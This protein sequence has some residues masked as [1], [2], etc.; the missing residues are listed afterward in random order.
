MSA[1]KTTR[2][3]MKILSVLLV[4]CLL[5]PLVPF[6]QPVVVEAAAA[7][8]V[9]ITVHQANI[10]N[11]TVKAE[12]MFINF[13]NKVD[14]FS[15]TNRNVDTTGMPVGTLYM[16]EGESIELTIDI[17]KNE[18]L[19]QLAASGEA[20]VELGWS[21]LLWSEEG[22][23]KYNYQGTYALMQV[24]SG[25]KETGRL[26][27]EA[28]HGGVGTRSL[29]VPIAEDTVIFIRVAGIRDHIGQKPVGVSGMYVRFKDETP[30]VLSSYSLTGDG[31]QRWN[32]TAERQEL[33]VKENEKID[34][35]YRFSEPV[36][37][38]GVLPTAN[39]PVTVAFLKHPLFVNTDQTGLPG[40]GVQQYLV[41]Q[42]YAA[43]QTSLGKYYSDITY[44]YTG[45]R[46]HQNGNPLQPAI[47]A[48]TEANLAPTLSDKFKAAEFI[49][50]AGNAA[51]VDFAQITAD[52]NSD[53]Y[54]RN[55]GI[56]NPFDFEN[57]GGFGIIVDAVRPKYS[58]TSN[59]IQPE[60]LTGVTVNNN[61]TIDFTVQFSE[62]V[63]PWR[64]HTSEWAAEDTYLEFN[65][66]MKAYYV[67]GSGTDKWK[68]RITLTDDVEL[69]TALLK[70]IALA[71]DNKDSDTLVLQ[72]YAGNMLFQ[73]A[74]YKGIHNDG[75]DSLMDSTIDWANLMIDNTKPDINFHFETGG[76]SADTY[77]KN[78]KVT[79]AADDP[80]LVVPPLEP[81]K[82]GVVLPEALPSRG[83]YRPTNMTGAGAPSVGLVYYIWSQSPDNP[84]ADKDGD[85]YAA[86]KRYSL[87]GK[88]PRED[89][90][91]NEY[92]DLNLAVVNNKTNMIA[93]PPE[94]LLPENSG[95]WYMHAWTADMTWDS[96]REL[97]QYEKMKTF[98]STREG[99]EQYQIWMDEHNGS[100][101]D[102]KTYA[103]AKALASVGN[104]VEWDL[105]DFKQADSNWNYGM[106]PFL[107]DN[108]QPDV[109]FTNIEGNAT[110]EAIVAVHLADPHSGLQSAS[111][112]FVRTGEQPS[113]AEWKSM[114]V[115]SG[116]NANI[117]TLN[118][119]Y[120]DGEYVLFVQASDAAGNQVTTSLEQTIVIDSTST[121]RVAF[122]P[123]ENTSYVKTHDVEYYLSGL[124]PASVSYA[125]SSSIVRPSDASAYTTVTASVYREAGDPDA[126]TAPP[127]GGEY[128][129]IIPINPNLNGMQYVHVVVD[130]GD[131]SRIYTYAKAYYFDNEPP[132]VGFSRTSVLYPQ[133]SHE[134]TVTVAE[135]AGRALVPIRLYQWVKEDEP[136]PDKASAGWS[137]LA[138]NGL[139]TIDAEEL[140]Q[141]GETANYRLYVY[142][143][144]AAGNG[145][146][147]STG[148]FAISR[149]DT[150][151]PPS[152]GESSL[153]HLYGDATDG[154]TG[155]I[156]LDLET[157]DKRGYEYSIS[158]DGG[159]SWS[160]WQ[161]YTNFVSTALPTN[162]V[163][164]LNIQV[165]FRKSG[166][167]A[168]EPQPLQIGELSVTEPVYAIARLSTTRPIQSATGVDIQITPPLGVKV[169]AAE[170]NPPTGLEQRGNSFK[171]RENGYYAF[172]LTDL[173]DPDR[174]DKLYVVVNNIDDTPPWG[175]IYYMSTAPTNGNAVVKLETMEPVTVLQLEIL[176]SDTL[177]SLSVLDNYGRNT[178]TFTQNGSVRFKFADEAGNIAAVIATV[179][180]IDKQSPNVRIAK[181]YQ[182]GL[183]T[184]ESFGT[185]RDGVGNVL[186]SSGVVLTVEK[187]HPQDK[188]FSVIG[189]ASSVVVQRNGTYS[190]TVSDSYGNTTQIAETVSNIVESGP[191]PAEVTYEFVDANGNVLPE[192]QVKTI[193]GKRYAKGKMRI[194]IAG[195]TQP[196]NIVFQGGTPILDE[197]GHYTNQISDA[198]GN[199]SLTRTVEDNGSMIIAL[200]DLVGNTNKLAL[201]VEGLDN[202]PPE[203]AVKHRVAGIVQ[204]KAGFDA[205]IDL[206]GYVASDNVSDA[207]NIAVT[208]S[209]LDLSKPGRQ[210]VTY[211]AVDEVGNSAQAKQDVYVVSGEGILIFANGMLISSSLGETALFDTNRLTF[212]ISGYDKMKVG[213]VDRINERATYDVLYQSGLY[214]EGQL[215]T[216]ATKLT[217]EELI[218]N[219]FTVT[220][221]KAGWYTI[222]VRTQEREREY[223]TFFVGSGT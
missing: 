22:F 215:K 195:Q 191:E 75:N 116:G 11:R 92:A 39:D 205:G 68:F 175:G 102:K 208:V 93:P 87:T 199:F 154:F 21:N 134:V 137:D 204:N 128:G 210:T 65:N 115:D 51:V 71:H 221:P 222:I 62:E 77:R 52:N 168:G 41:N 36:R 140:L 26:E 144:D 49:D 61:D 142:A 47:T 50:A 162:V 217:Y 1:Y 219:N 88:Q 194:S 23:P 223:A 106:T 34:L 84:F 66:G 158:A 146:T 83:I 133:Q 138:E 43:N 72:D 139:V 35:I 150:S 82:P 202:T 31:L 18:K 74:N 124:E 159:T 167:T 4:I 7:K 121:V 188:D 79:I 37:P 70:V 157:P 14:G 165:K 179:T 171:V 118:H 196:A 55:K 164:R 3:S 98:L 192:S 64:D 54:L 29:T 107:L 109:T 81:E 33:Y 6:R 27:E 89:L 207:A 152:A 131:G 201:T 117:S 189:G 48:P 220:F 101:S 15:Y 103:D 211:T 16:H 24:T 40:E 218:S 135:E 126:V 78:G 20:V 25:K 120:E 193:N 190:F 156:R 182:Y 110:S 80:D 67:S 185:I 130:P 151:L 141:P 42:Q 99:E 46:Y 173:A 12:N 200:T 13:P 30:P 181:T 129:Y 169:K 44:R 91:P 209:G 143:E 183:G 114:S 38:N 212:E 108:L 60:I 17:S 63:I 160:R 198:A 32:S 123:K 85:R 174:K 8:D 2:K 100:E 73:P 97:M 155:I 59:G 177:E 111:F 213:G 178:Y 113:G 127:T 145:G 148:L 28:Y 96:A 94:A 10:G 184:N 206:G 136:A 149:S 132:I 153:I 203:I 95:I 125:V 119:I 187:V 176:D 9:P 56:N 170:D 5:L 90:Y 112:Q 57:E 76:A 166:G 186:A 163:E 69:E 122:L 147:Y 172:D 216:I 19:R 104:Y 45:V 197:T 161:P 214:R 53:P 58:K 105:A 180:N 86:L